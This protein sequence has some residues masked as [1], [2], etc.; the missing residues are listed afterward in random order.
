[1]TRAYAEVIG[2]PIAHSKSPLIHN[3]WLKKLGID[4]EYRVCHVRAQELSDYFAERRKDPDWR[5]CNV[6]LPHKV[7]AIEFLDNAELARL[8]PGAINTVARGNGGAL[9][10]ANTDAGGFLRP[11]AD[12]P[13]AGME[14]IVIGTGGAARGILSA[15]AFKQ[16][17]SVSILARDLAKAAA[18]LEEFGLAG[19]ALPLNA[20]L[21]AAGLLVNASVLGMD[22]HPGFT[23]DLG[24]LPADAIVYDIVYTPLV[25]PLL[26]SAQARNLTTIDGLEM[27]IGQAALAFTLLFGSAPLSEYD[28]E[29][30]ALLV[31]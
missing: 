16:V 30:R 10:G 4:A 15:L 2:D 21:P 14:A 22:G 5:G 28:G 12:H 31:A 23:P 29:L 11:L 1:M 18:L 9:I 27:L 7:T 20:P 13:L 19:H 25:T 26:A 3:F 6:T 8:A 24:S 17:A